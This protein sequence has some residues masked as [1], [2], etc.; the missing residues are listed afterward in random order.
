MMFLWAVDKIGLIGVT[1]SFIDYKFFH[2]S[3][4]GKI[5]VFTY[6]MGEL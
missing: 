4:Y 5:H 2:I 6:A 1:I 3:K